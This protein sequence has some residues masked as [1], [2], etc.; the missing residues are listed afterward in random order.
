MNDQPAD[1][2]TE[3][4]THPEPPSDEELQTSLPV[5]PDP[6]QPAYDAVY[7]YIRGLDTYLPPD[8][9]HRNAVIWRAVQA[10]LDATHLGR[11]VSSHCVE[12]DHMVATA[13]ESNPATTEPELTAEEDEAERFK[14]DYLS[15]CKTIA[16]MHAAATGRT[17]EGPERGVVED[18][19]DVRARM[20]AA[21][22]RAENFEGRAQAYEQRAQYQADRTARLTTDRDRLRTRLAE[23]ETETMRQ[24]QR[25]EQAEAAIARV[26]ALHRPADH[27]GLLICVECSCYDGSSTDNSPC[28]YEHCPTNA[29]LEGLPSSATA[30]VVDEGR[31]EMVA[32]LGDDH[33]NV[34]P[35]EAL[36]YHAMGLSHRVERAEAERD[37]AYRERAY[38][39]ALLAAMTD[40]AVIAPAVDVEE[41]GWQIVYLTI[42]GRQASWH[43][44]PRDADLFACVPHVDT[45][46]P[47]AQWDGHTTEDK[48]ADIRQHTRDLFHQCGPACAE[49]HTYTDRCEGAHQADDS[50]TTTPDVV[51]PAT[52][53]QA[54][55]P[56]GV[57]E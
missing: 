23:Q 24:L 1:P 22:E 25:A 16:D 49:G 37:G 42:G 45:D 44:S 4:D 56:H 11:C 41:P 52:E 39:V 46:H 30:A 38:L 29:A 6:R 48:Y 57:D 7:G 14:A 50:D 20:L 21:E 10:A 54:S 13:E 9:V 51:H 36:A 43:I 31:Q 47:R 19:A 27:R 3:D 2:A 8:P 17:G 34:Q 5:R 18:V 32:E 35:E 15:A 28:G 12:A 40:G 53:P 26:R 55:S 33:R